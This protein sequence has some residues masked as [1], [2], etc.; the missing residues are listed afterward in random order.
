MGHNSFAV[1]APIRAVSLY[2]SVRALTEV[3]GTG[4]IDWGAVAEA[5]KASTE[6][7]ALDL[8]ERERRG[9]AGDVRDARTR[10][11]DVGGVSFDLPNQI[12]VQ[13][14]HHWIDANVATFERVMRPIEDRSQGLF[15]EFARLANTSSMALALS[16]LGS[17][18][19]GQYDPLLLAESDGADDH[20]LYFVHPNIGRVARELEVPVERFRRWIA[21]HEVTHAAEFGAAPWL[22]DHLEARMQRGIE[23][24]ADGDLDREAFRELNVAMTAVEGYAELLMDEA[25]DDEYEDLRRKLDE[26]RQGRGPLARLIGRVL[27][28]GMKR[29]Q[30]VRGKSF[31]TDVVAER[32]IEGASAVWRSPEHLPTDAELDEPEKWLARVI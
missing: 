13:H 28:L 24:L 12:E 8:T 6:P 17:N 11:Q 18:V 30:Y 15:P 25:F 16:F 10:V 26:R 4:P 32:G 23:A 14:R 22:S 2:D 27:G 29:R 20:A 19:L 9:Y 1:P 21:F 7:G 5:A 3:S 31:F